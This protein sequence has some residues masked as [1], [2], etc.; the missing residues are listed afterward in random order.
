MTKF[1]IAE[2]MVC[3]SGPIVAMARE[4]TL[5]ADQLSLTDGIRY[6]Q[7]LYYSTFTTRDFSEGI[8]VFKRDPRSEE[9]LRLVY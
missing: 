4:A 3:Y 9:R 1:L 5:Q 8:Q 2:K 6:E 7:S